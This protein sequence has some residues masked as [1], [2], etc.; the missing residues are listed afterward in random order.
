MVLAFIVGVFVTILL[1]LVLAYALGDA[2]PV[3]G[4]DEQSG[5]WAERHNLLKFIIIGISFYLLFFVPR[6]MWEDDKQQCDILLDNT[7]VTDNTT[8]YSYSRQ[9]FNTSNE[10]GLDFFKIYGKV[11]W[12]LGLYSLIMAVILLFKKIREWSS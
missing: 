1:L 2:M 10:T 4:L 12:L 9:C 8:S 3:V 6:V 5:Y 11:L 7:T